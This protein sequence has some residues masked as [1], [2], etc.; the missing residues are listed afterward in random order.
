MIDPTLQWCSCGYH[1][2]P[3]LYQKLVMLVCGHYMKTC[4]RCQTQ[5]RLVMVEHVVC[6][7]RENV[8]KTELWKRS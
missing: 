2:R 4:P 8:D 3:G 6:I 7:E 5:M 1:W